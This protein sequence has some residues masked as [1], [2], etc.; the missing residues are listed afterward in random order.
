MA[1]AGFVVWLA[2]LGAGLVCF[3]AR[4][5]ATGVFFILLGGLSALLRFTA[6]AGAHPVSWLAAAGS[7]VFWVALGTRFLVGQPA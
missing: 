6:G 5:R 2:L 4:P 3:P 1:L 7:A